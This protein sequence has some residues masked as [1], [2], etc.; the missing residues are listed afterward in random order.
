M[1]DVQAGLEA[2]AETEDHLHVLTP[3]V[4]K[5]AART[6]DQADLET[7]ART[8]DHQHV[9]VE[10]KEEV[11]LTETKTMTADQRVQPG[12]RGVRIWLGAL[13]RAI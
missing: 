2:K 8:E 13:K 12:N 4:P 10:M 3:N 7:K 1:T 9:V 6:E 11:A 5:A